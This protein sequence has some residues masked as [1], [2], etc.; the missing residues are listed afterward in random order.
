MA[1][2]KKKNNDIEKALQELEEIVEKLK[3]EDMSVDDA[4]KLYEKGV[5]SCETCEKILEEKKQKIE[6]VEK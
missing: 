1:T 2:S 4:T 5:A 3:K 6:F